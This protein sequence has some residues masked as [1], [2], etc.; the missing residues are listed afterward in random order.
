MADIITDVKPL[1]YYDYIA[2]VDASG[3]DGYKFMPNGQGSSR[4][5]AVAMFVVKKEDIEY[6]IKIL[7]EIKGL[8]G[9]KPEHEVKYTTLRRNKKSIEI[10]DIV[11]KLR[12]TLVSWIAFK[13]SITDPI[14]LDVKNKVLPQFC[15]VFPINSVNNVLKDEI[16]TNIL[17][18]VDVMKKVEMDG[19]KHLVEDTFNNNKST[20]ENHINNYNI[21]FKDSKDKDFQLI[22]IADILSGIIRTS[23]ESWP[24]E[25][26]I[27]TRC[28]TC[29]S[30]IHTKKAKLLCKY[31][32]KGTHLENSNNLFKIIPLFLKEETYNR[33]VLYGI[34]PFPVE[35]ANKITFID[36][37]LNKEYKIRNYKSR[38]PKKGKK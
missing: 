6:N 21:K 25:H 4:C 15:H 22:Q 16:G 34:S 13:E 33:V 36:C 32:N 26:E 37:L 31:K 24:L 27:W 11:S 5:Y 1:D 10:H 17:I 35:F 28:K 8:V 14:F 7:D 38:K 19:V 30:L 9:C 2:Y 12:G 18:A 29:N 23:F 20:N 3:D